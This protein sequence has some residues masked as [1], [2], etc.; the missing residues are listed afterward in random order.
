MNY[1]T[2]VDKLER[3]KSV[4]DYDPHML[5]THSTVGLLQ[6][7]PEVGVEALHHDEDVLFVHH[8]YIV[9][10]WSVTIF[11]FRLGFLLVEFSHDLNFSDGL[12][13][14]VAAAG[15]AVAGDELD[16]Y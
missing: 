8:D 11:N 4:E 14:S 5:F 3:A 15:L 7:V 13:E 10:F 1:V 6:Q 16:G 12:H 2:G 9:Q